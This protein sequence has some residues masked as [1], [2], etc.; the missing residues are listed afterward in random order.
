MCPRAVHV[1]VEG[2]RRDG[3]QR[4]LDQQEKR[5]KSATISCQSL[6]EVKHII[7]LQQGQVVIMPGMNQLVF[8]AGQ[9]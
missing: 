5:E 9:P 2:A 7:I 4:F 8:Q 1:F 3:R 6:C